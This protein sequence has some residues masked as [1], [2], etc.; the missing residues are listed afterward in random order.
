MHVV[1]RILACLCIVVEESYGIGILHTPYGLFTK[2]DDVVLMNAKVVRVTVSDIAEC[3][4]VCFTRS[5]CKSFN[6]KEA[7]G[8][9]YQCELKHGGQLVPKMNNTE[10]LMSERVSNVIK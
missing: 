8:G 7:R 4:V 10:W 6:I 5:E 3:A 2:T 9:S 1:Y